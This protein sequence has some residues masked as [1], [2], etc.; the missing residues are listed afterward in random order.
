MI[1]SQE[2]L[3]LEAVE[4]VKLFPEIVAALDVHVRLE[5]YV[6]RRSVVYRRVQIVCTY[7]GFVGR[8]F[9]HVET[10]FRGRVYQRLVVR[11]IVRTGA[12][13]FY[14]GYDMR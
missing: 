1:V 6:R 14:A 7:I 12:A 5:R 2:F 3:A 13:Q 11:A 10:A 9:L 8:D 4:V